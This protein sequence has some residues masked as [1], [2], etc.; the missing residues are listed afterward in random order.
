MLAGEQR[1]RLRAVAAAG[2]G[3]VMA[4]AGV[5]GVR[6]VSLLLLLLLLL[7]IACVLDKGA[8]EASA[9]AQQWQA[10]TGLC[11]AGMDCRK[12]PDPASS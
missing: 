11:C 5:G 12:R 8:R 10:R 3:V 7:G 1:S 9:A 4:V 2:G 6:G